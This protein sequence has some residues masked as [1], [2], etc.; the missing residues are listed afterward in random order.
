MQFYLEKEL[1]HQ[2]MSKLQMINFEKLNKLV[3][4]CEINLLHLKQ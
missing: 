1:S 2:R 3:T 4:L